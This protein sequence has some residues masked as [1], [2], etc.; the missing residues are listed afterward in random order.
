MHLDIG[1]IVKGLKVSVRFRGNITFSIRESEGDEC[2]FTVCDIY[3]QITLLKMESLTN[4]LLMKIPMA[5]KFVILLFF[6][7]NA[8]IS[9]MIHSLVLGNSITHNMHMM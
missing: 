9:L 1:S 7:I 3:M 2:S 8:L 6:L 4:N 5:N